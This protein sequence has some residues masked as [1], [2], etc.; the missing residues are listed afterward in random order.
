MHVAKT[1]LHSVECS[2]VHVAKIHVHKNKW[3]YVRNLGEP[4][5]QERYKKP[6][7]TLLHLGEPSNSVTRVT[8]NEGDPGT[9]TT[10]SKELITLTSSYNSR[11]SLRRM[12]Y[13]SSI[14]Y[15]FFFKIYLSFMELHRAKR[16][17]CLVETR[18]KI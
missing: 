4:S 18:Q 1:H 16:S 7:I 17:P 11:S 10:S 2:K 15:T 9:F 6:C 12:V 5:P 13:F 14:A 8:K 3:V